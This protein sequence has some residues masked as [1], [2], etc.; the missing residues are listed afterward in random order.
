MIARGDNVPRYL[1]ERTFNS[2]V[3]I[4]QCEGGEPACEAIVQSNAK[5]GVTWLQSYV[6]EDRQKLYCIYDGPN[7][8][9]IRAAA[10]DSNL[11]IDKIV[12]VRVLDPGA[13]R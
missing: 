1:I 6:S 5:R 2:G 4:P 3:Q 11:P 8:E 13:Y 10:L 9:A 7:P 12:A